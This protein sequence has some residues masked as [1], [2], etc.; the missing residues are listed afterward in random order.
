MDRITEAE[1]VHK[2]GDVQVKIQR[3]ERGLVFLIGQTK[4][5]TKQHGVVDLKVEI[6][7]EANNGETAAVTTVREAGPIRGR[8][9]SYWN[10]EEFFL[11]NV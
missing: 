6:V 2:Y 3:V 8:V 11:D 9:S 10:I 4:G 7:V 1:F 5:N